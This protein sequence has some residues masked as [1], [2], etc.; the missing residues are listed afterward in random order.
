MKNLRRLKNLHLI[1]FILIAGLILFV[2]GQGAQLAHATQETQTVQKMDKLADGHY[3]IDYVILR[4]EDDSVSIANDYFQKKAGLTIRNGEPYLFITLSQS[5]W[6]QSLKTQSGED[7]IES[8]VQSHDSEQN[9]RIVY[10]KLRDLDEPIMLQMHIVISSMQPVY[11]HKYTVRLQLNPSS[12]ESAEDPFWNV[13]TIELNGLNSVDSP[14]PSVFQLIGYGVISLAI[15]VLFLFLLKK[16][17]AKRKP[18]NY[19]TND[20]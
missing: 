16:M 9:T 19:P 15:A 6:I 7:F 2:Q 8:A 14:A 12:L 10:W 18:T 5:A 11:D 20:R 1:F 3:L 17:L 4:T 13:T